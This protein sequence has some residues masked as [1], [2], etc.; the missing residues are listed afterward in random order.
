M[1]AG[2]HQLEPLIGKCHLL[3]LVLRGLAHLEQ[4]GLGRER[5][6]A[7]QAVDRSVARS[8]RQPG[9]RIG[10]DPVARPALGRDRERFLRGFL[11]EIEVAEKA[12]QR[13]QN[14]AP[15]L[16]EDRLEDR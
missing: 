5:A 1:T 16:A 11:G 2:E 12:N 7:A 6:I 10:G 15:L 3:C 13:S 4:A 8:G 14:T 9:A